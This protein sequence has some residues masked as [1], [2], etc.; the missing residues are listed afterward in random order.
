VTVRGYQLAVDWS[1]HSTYA[2]TLEDVSGHVLDE[3]DVTVAYGRIEGRT[4]TDPAIGKLTFSLRNDGRQFSPENTSSPITGQVL[5]G[6][7]VQ[8][9]YTPTSTGSTAVLFSGPLDQFDIDPNAPARDFS[10]EALDGWGT[11]NAEKLSTP[12]YSGLRTGD[13]IGI[14]LD[15]IGWTGLRDLDP[16]AT[17]VDYWWAEGDSAA[18]AVQKLVQSEGPPAIAYVQGGVFVFRDRHHRLTR[19]ASQTSQG[20]YAHVIP[21]AS[22]PAGQ[23]KILRNSFAYDHG[24]Q[25]IAN[26]AVFE[27]EQRQPTGPEEVWSTQTPIV[28]AANETTTIIAQA[29]DPFVDAQVPGP[30]TYNSDGSIGAGEYSL[31]Y[32]TIT[33]TLARTSGQAV[34]ITL[35]AGGT[36]AYL[37]DGLKL[38]ATP[39]KVARTV[40]VIEEDASSIGRYRRQAWEQPAPWANAYDARAIAQRVVAI[41][42]TPRPSVVLSIVNLDDT[43]IAQIVGRVIS[44]RI[45]I[46]N[47]ELG[48]NADFLVEGIRHAI[49][50]WGALHTLTLYC[51]I[52]EPTQPSNIFTFDVAGK[53]FDDG[54]FGI[55]GID[56]AATMFRFDVA[57]QGFD[58][59]VFST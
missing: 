52:A 29:S 23:L 45:T 53:G 47:D 44:D 41:Y 26:S 43:Y 7:N 13:L 5:P 34:A 10:A 57:G 49:R 22:G 12:V 20:T 30:Y 37:E 25:H 27:V 48:L 35:T 38:R 6:A 55:N 11:P 17:V 4:T 32:G 36:G 54:A 31:Q 40:K 16:G 15:E 3:P 18:E 9:T 33:I 14:V 59:G 21:E 42:A 24:L 39:I 51:E 1:R 50:M 56:N 58:Q 28:L 46:R 8:L 19:T 2:N